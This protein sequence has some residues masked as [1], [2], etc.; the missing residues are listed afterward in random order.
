[1]KITTL[2]E[3]RRNKSDSKLAAEWGLSLHIDFNDHR[4]LFDSGFSGSIVK[5]AEYL[6]VDLA[7]VDTAVLSHHHFDHGNGF[8]R[9]FEINQ[10]A[11]VHLGEAPLGECFGGRGPL[12]R[13][14]VSIRDF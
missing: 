13:K 1:M 14:Y 5:N 10:T 12:L 8:R 7:S 11:K 3:N 4:I 6:A 2:I 9:F